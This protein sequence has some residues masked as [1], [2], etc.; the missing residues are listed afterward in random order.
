[1]SLPRSVGHSFDML[2]M[3]LNSM[4]MAENFLQKLDGHGDDEMGRLVEDMLLGLSQSKNRVKAVIIDLGNWVARDA[5]Q[6]DRPQKDEQ[7]GEVK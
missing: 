5:E 7:R 1:M 4:R 6:P 2:A 3:S